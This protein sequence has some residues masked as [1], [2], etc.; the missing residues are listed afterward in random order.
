MAGVYSNLAYKV[1]INVY[2]SFII[3]LSIECS[4]VDLTIDFLENVSEINLEEV[5]IHLV[6]VFELSQAFD[7]ITPIITASVPVIK[8][9]INPLKFLDKTDHFY[10]FQT[11][12]QSNVFQ[13]YKFDFEE[14]SKVKVDLTF[15]DFKITP[16]K[17]QTKESVKW[18]NQAIRQSPEIKPLIQVIK[19]FLYN[20]ALNSSFNG[21]LSSFAVF[22][23]IIA[24][25]KNNKEHIK[26]N[27]GRLL[28][29]FFEIYGR[30]LNFSQ[31]IINVNSYK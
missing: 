22:L 15:I 16:S 3:D 23:M 30:F 9:I 8:L 10:K 17:K 6:K 27:L 29:E 31:C 7:M 13:D 14:I 1:D 28:Y 5:F 12:T 25:I 20:R 19:R 4:D 2:G 24:I 18:A 11:F 26:M 21:S